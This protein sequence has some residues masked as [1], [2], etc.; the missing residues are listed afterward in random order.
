VQELKMATF[1]SFDL[2]LLKVHQGF[3]CPTKFSTSQKRAFIE[4]RQPMDVYVEMKVKI[5]TEITQALGVEYLDTAEAVLNYLLDMENGYLRVVNNVWTFE[6]DERQILWEVLAWEIVPHLARRVAFASLG[7]VLDGG[8]PGG[9]FWYLPGVAPGKE[10]GPLELPVTQVLNWFMDLVGRPLEQIADD[11]S[12]SSSDNDLGESFLRSFNNWRSGRSTPEISKIEQYFNDGVEIR[13]DNVFELRAGVDVLAQYDDAVRYVNSRGLGERELVNEIQMTAE[14]RIGSVLN[15]SASD[16]EKKYFVECVERRY[17]KPSMKLVRQRLRMARMFQDGYVALLKYLCPGV[18]PVCLDYGK[19]KVMQLVD[20]YR[21]LANFTNEAWLKKR[22]EGEDAENAYFEKLLMPHDRL[23][24]YA[25]IMVSLGPLGEKFTHQG[26]QERFKEMRPGD[27]LEDQFASSFADEDD[28]S[29]FLEI[30]ERDIRRLDAITGFA[31]S[32][33]ELQDE[34]R[35]GSAWRALQSVDKFDV[36]YSVAETLR[37]SLKV[38]KYA[39]DRLHEL[40]VTDDERTRLLVLELSYL[41]EGD[42]KKRSVEWRTRVEMLLEKVDSLSDLGI[43]KAPLLRLKGLH[44][45]NCNKFDEA[46]RFFKEAFTETGR[47]GYGSLRGQ[48]ARECFAIQVSNAWLVE[49][50]HE[51]YYRELLRSGLYEKKLSVSAGGTGFDPLKEEVPEIQDIARDVYEYF[52]KEMYRPYVGLQKKGGYGGSD[53]E[54]RKLF[55]SVLYDDER[56]MLEWYKRNPGRIGER[57]RGVQGDTPLIGLIKA[58]FGVL[59]EG[60]LLDAYGRKLGDMWSVW[61]DMISFEANRQERLVV[62]LVG[63]CK[64]SDLIVTDFKGQNAFMLAVNANRIEIVKAMLEKGVDPDLK[65]YRGRAALHECIRM[66]LSDCARLLIDRGCSVSLTQDSD[67]L[68]PIHMAVVF[69]H[70]DIAQMILS[71]DP[72]VI[73]DMDEQRGWTPL[74]VVQCLLNNDDARRI[75]EDRIRSG[76]HKP[77]SRDDLVAV[78]DVLK[79][80]EKGHIG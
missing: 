43:W 31:K 4:F 24:R 12:R 35:R 30:A 64:V 73:R 76:G 72:R 11:V 68:K 47:T 16:K 14:G 60:G 13:F 65:D 5:V 19:N 22:D 37:D 25:S 36:I 74:E 55:E 26:L 2:M 66:G 23:G 6:A 7:K 62:R 9:R 59:E 46:F 78:Y 32:V 50:N 44:L 34:M 42:E 48:L 67:G 57:M 39:L 53:K 27:A 52:W 51:I 1:P 49:N 63:L 54:F 38:R 21:T 29:R 28:D 15:G 58:C 80:A 40:A 20:M 45:V 79:A 33:S 71:K 77:P 75:S 56:A 3:G 70:A 10:E 61:K 69:G 41:L 17:S 8:M 18:S